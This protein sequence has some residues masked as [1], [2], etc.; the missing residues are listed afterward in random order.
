MTISSISDNLH[1]HTGLFMKSIWNKKCKEKKKKS[2]SSWWTTSAQNYTQLLSLGLLLVI[3][4]MSS[5][6][7]FVGIIFR[8]HMTLETGMANTAP[9]DVIKIWSKMNEFLATG[10]ALGITSLWGRDVRTLMFIKTSNRQ[11][12]LG[13][14]CTWKHSPN[15][16]FAIMYL[17]TGCFGKVLIAW[18]AVVFL[19]PYMFCPD[20]ILQ[21]LCPR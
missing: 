12:L 1:A 10:F 2:C 11:E 4:Q 18:F 5:E 8:A 15:S 20:V 19:L 13:T 21:G 3:F 17:K 14:F 7:P 16:M 9:L 6:I